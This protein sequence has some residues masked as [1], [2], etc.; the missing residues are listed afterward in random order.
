MILN[1]R[2]D[3]ATWPC[4][5]L[6]RVL[7]IPVLRMTAQAGQRGGRADAAVRVA[8]GAA[9]NLPNA[10]LGAENETKEG[11]AFAVKVL[12]DLAG[13]LLQRPRDLLAPWPGPPG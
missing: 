6:R 12:L 1:M 8:L 7:G 9:G 5:L 4:W 11:C 3:A 10:T 2:E 13:G